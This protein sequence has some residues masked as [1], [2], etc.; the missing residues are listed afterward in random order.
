MTNSMLQAEY[1]PI[2]REA[3]VL[4]SAG[5]AAGAEEV[6]R[7]HVEAPG[8]PDH[9]AIVMLLEL[10]FRLGKRFEF[11]EM[12]RRYAAAFDLPAKPAWGLPARVSG[13][14]TFE[15]EGTL[16]KAEHLAGLLPHARGRTTVAID[17]SHVERIDYAFTPAFCEALRL[18]HLQGKRVILANIAELHA[19]LLESFDLRHVVLLR[20]W[21]NDSPRSAAETGAWTPMPAANETTARAMA[22]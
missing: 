12:A 19:A 17:M 13:A 21:K 1:L 10:L 5:Y 20:R 2:T 7:A 16:G 11:D 9:A 4:Y 14:D 6:L 3:S 22:A 15:L 18:L 8:A